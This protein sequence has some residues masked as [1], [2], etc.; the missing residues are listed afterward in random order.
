MG[1][2]ED[3]NYD[4][5]LERVLVGLV[6]VGNYHFVFE[7]CIWCLVTFKVMCWCNMAYKL[8]LFI[9]LMFT[10]RS[11]WPCKKSVKR[12]LRV[13]VLLSTCSC[14]RQQF[15]RVGYYI[16]MTTM[17]NNKRKSVLKVLIDRVQDIILADKPS[18]TKF[19]INS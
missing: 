19:P 18:V 10:G 13:K 17:M 15:I 14:L 2:A 12:L 3:E 6:N 4:Q 5:L 9:Y 8:V 7:V 11:S 16:T 1:P